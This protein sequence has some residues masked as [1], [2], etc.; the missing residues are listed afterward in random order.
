VG[1]KKYDLCLEV[2]SRFSKKGLLNKLVLVGSWC[3]YFYEDFFAGLHYTPAI[4]T[5]DIDLVVPL[6]PKI[7]KEVDI[8]KLLE[9]LG[10]VVGFVGSKG[11]MRLNHPDLIVEFLVPERGKGSD[12]PYQLKNLGVNAQPLRYLDFLTA[13]TM[14]VKIDNMIVNVPHPAAF[15]LHKLI[16]ARR[17][18]KKHKSDKDIQQALMIF[19]FFKKKGDFIKLRRIFE[20]MHKKWQRD[21]LGN[22][23]ILDREDIIEILLV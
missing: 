6:P 21:V 17:R 22:L 1:K 5:R 12:K 10:F 3:L 23:R 8:P 4:R 19:D 16:I 11:Y 20:S 14:R 7:K 13:N 18:G 15:A 9:D 2:L